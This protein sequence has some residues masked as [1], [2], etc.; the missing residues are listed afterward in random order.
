MPGIRKGNVLGVGVSIVDYDKA[1]DAIVEAAREHKPF[2]VASLPVHGI[3]TGAL[4]REHRWRLNHFDMITPDGQPVRWALNSLHGA[5]LRERV[6]GPEL[7]ARVCKRAAR[8]G[9]P[10]FLFGGRP[11]V[12]PKLR[13]ELVKMAPGI[14]IAGSRA[15]LYR[16]ATEAETDEIESHIRESGAKI[17][18][19]GLGCPRQETWIHEFSEKLG[20]PTLAVGAAFDF[21]A[22][23]VKQAPPVLQDRGLEWLYRLAKEPRRLWR[24][25]VLLN[26]AFLTLWALQALGLRSFSDVGSP[27]TTTENFG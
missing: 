20:V 24:R 4:N 21:H 22:G 2:K 26:P 27:P 17:V 7:M 9:I 6:Y 23:A 25:Y 19:V 15:A 14:K 3:M 5:G 16:R 10:V 18:F 1:V 13:E 12:L 11:E 8:D